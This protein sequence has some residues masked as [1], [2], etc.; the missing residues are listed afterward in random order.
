MR[1]RA[2][3]G[4]AARLALAIAIGSLLPAHLPA[5]QHTRG[6]VS[7]IVKDDTGQPISD[8][9]VAS[10]GS[11]TMVRT[12]SA[13]QFMVSLRAGP[14]DLTFRRLAFAPIVL[15]MQVFP[16]DTSNVEVTLTVVAHTLTGQIVLADPVHRRILTEFESRRKLGFGHFITRAEIARRDPSE[17]SDMVRLV[18]GTN[19]ILGEN[20]RVRLRFARTAG[21]DCPPEYYVD[22]I[23]APGLN[24]D[25][26]PPGDVEG[27][28]LYAG[29]ASIPPQY[30]R[31]YS[32]S[33]CGVI[34]I[35]TR[36]PGNDA[37]KP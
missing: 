21:R 11:T 16:N 22:G 18:P 19:L 4:W 24:I 32:T 7:G 13:G 9:Q 5:Q 8:V 31:V 6:V 14:A 15:M 28:E 17:L 30:N 36:I 2:L 12:D 26:T 23:M 1:E 29:A 20:G 35:W 25:D 10:L 33:N 3:I 34:L 27:V 37:G